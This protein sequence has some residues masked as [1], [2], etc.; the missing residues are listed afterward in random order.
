M[1]E[2]PTVAE[3]LLI[4]RREDTAALR[5]QANAAKVMNETSGLMK[6]RELETI[7]RIATAG[8][9]RV[10]LGEKGLT[11]QMLKLL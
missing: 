9:L 5:H 6:F 3:A 11:E 1:I 4:K 8:K 7:E 2:A 10:V